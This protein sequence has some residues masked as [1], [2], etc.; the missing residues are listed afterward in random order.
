MNIATVLKKNEAR[1]LKLPNVTGV[2][3]GEKNGKEIILVFVT[4]KVPES[5]LDIH[6]RIPKRIEGFEVDVKVRLLIGN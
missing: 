3:I 2:G 4:H 6:Q 5:K 1:L